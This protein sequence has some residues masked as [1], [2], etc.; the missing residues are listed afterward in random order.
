MSTLKSNQYINTVNHNLIS[1]KNTF[2]YTYRYFYGHFLGVVVIIEGGSLV[3][4]FFNLFLGVS[5]HTP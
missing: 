3:G 5:S 4:V 1:T 2:F